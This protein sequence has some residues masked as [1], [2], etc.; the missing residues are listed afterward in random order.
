[1]INDLLEKIFKIRIKK[2]F[3]E[4]NN[5]F[6]YRNIFP[7]SSYNPWDDDKDFMKIYSVISEYTLVDMYRCYEIYNLVK[8]IESLDGDI[9]EV[10]TFKGGTSGIISSVISKFKKNKTFYAIDTFEGVVKV[11]ENDPSYVGGEHKASID[12]IKELHNKLKLDLPTILHGIYPDDFPDVTID[13]VSF[14]HIDVDIYQSAKDIYLSLENFV[15]SGGIILFDDYGFKGTSGV[16]KFCNEIKFNDNYK[17]IHNL[18]GHA[19][20]IKK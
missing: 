7:S 4:V 2:I 16:T 15:E 11:D 10:G 8:Q 20:F 6:S 18:N 3:H 17:Y 1:M 5:G 14:L 13:K 12:D 19:I 9:V